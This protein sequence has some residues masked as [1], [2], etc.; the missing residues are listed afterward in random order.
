MQAKYQIVSS[1]AVVQVDWPMYG[2][3]KHK[4]NPYLKASWKENGYVDKA[5]IFSIMN[6]FG[7]KLLNANVQCVYIV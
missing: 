5:V 1:K 2:L 4:H 3:F 6:F 7:T